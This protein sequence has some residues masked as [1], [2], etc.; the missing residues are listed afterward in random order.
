MFERIIYIFIIVI[1]LVLVIGFASI[2][3]H[4]RNQ[5][6]QSHVC[7]AGAHLQMINNDPVCISAAQL[8]R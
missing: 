4:Q 2:T 8:R 7:P 3:D 5:I 1:L 6:E